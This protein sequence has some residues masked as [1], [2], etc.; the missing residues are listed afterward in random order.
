MNK[1]NKEQY[2]KFE[3]VLKSLTSITRLTKG[4]Q[5]DR[6][7]PSPNPAYIWQQAAAVSQKNGP[8]QHQMADH[9]ELFVLK[10]LF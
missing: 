10:G 9:N 6:R 3:Y 1:I 5:I 7:T 8:N 4:Q 2:L